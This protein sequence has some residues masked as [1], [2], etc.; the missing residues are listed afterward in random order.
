[1]RWDELSLGAP[2]FALR[3]GAGSS[4]DRVGFG[5]GGGIY[6]AIE[7]RGETLDDF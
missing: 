7:A 3:G 6:A 4:C 5:G 1:M 2:G